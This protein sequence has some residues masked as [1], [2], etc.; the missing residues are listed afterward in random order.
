MKSIL[1]ITLAIPG[2][3]RSSKQI[4]LQDF[5]P[6]KEKLA[7]NFRSVKLNGNS[8]FSWDKFTNQTNYAHLNQDSI[9]LSDMGVTYRPGIIDT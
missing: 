5:L 4:Q 8:E 6:S 9:N 1:L 3:S 7:D 2:H